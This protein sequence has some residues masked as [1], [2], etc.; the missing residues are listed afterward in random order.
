MRVLFGNEWKEGILDYFKH[1]DECRIEVRA[2]VV[3]EELNNLYFK[4]PK[5]LRLL[6]NYFTEIGL[7]NVIRKIIS[8][9]NEGMRNQK[10]LSVGI[11]RILEDS[12]NSK[13]QTNDLVAFIAPMHPHFSERIVLPENLLT[14]MDKANLQIDIQD[15]LYFKVEPDPS[16][17][18]GISCLQGW[19]YFSGID[20]PESIEEMLDSVIQY[21]GG[22]IWRDADIFDDKRSKVQ[23]CGKALST[24]N[25]F[26]KKSAVLFGYGNYAKT[27][28]LPNI[29]QDIIINR[30]HEVDPFQ[31]PI[32]HDE[33]IVW[34]TSPFFRGDESFDAFFIAGYHHTHA[35]L[36]VEALN[37]D[38]YAVIEKPVVVNAQQLKSLLSAMKNTNKGV[39]SCFHK[40]YLPLNDMAFE[41]MGIKAGDG[42]VSYHCIV[43]EVPLPD[44]HWYKWKNSKSRLISNGCHWIDHFLFLN[45]YCEA[46]SFDLYVSNDGTINC[47]IELQNGAVFSMLLTDV[48]SERI[49]VQDYIELR[50]EN[51]TVTMHNGSAYF[52]ENSYKVIRKEKINKMDSYTNMYKKI[53]RSIRENIEGDTLKSVKVS[54][55]LILSLEDKLDGLLANSMR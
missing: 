47:S 51:V 46:D 6:W 14:K 34:D 50:H 15:R 38:S 31:I 4:R 5:S 18:E 27:V 23:E 16:A 8:R 25:N 41:D 1:S 53:G 52:S 54:S 45:D 36:A 32:N 24:I 44:L 55:E 33:K 43:Y 35:D 2:S 10:Y 28:V 26:N 40:R 48:G 22:D 19:N 17:I 7:I 39:F 21:L 11:A 20:F 42:P 13:F 29:K 37:N 9:S 12:E 3:L 30:I 49:G